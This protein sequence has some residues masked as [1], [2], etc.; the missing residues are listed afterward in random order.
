ARDI[1]RMR[2][3]LPRNALSA[4]EEFAGRDRGLRLEVGSGLTRFVV[5][6]PAA[7]PRWRESRGGRRLVFQTLPTEF[8]R[9]RIAV[10]AGREVFDLR[11]THFDY[12]QA[13]SDA[14]LSAFSGTDLG[15]AAA[16]W[17]PLR[18]GTRWRIR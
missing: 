5:A 4:H 1:L 14:T 9:I 11:V 8:P 13:P 16:A 3:R 2:G 10:D 15:R 12:P 18:G 17:E 7:D 6:V